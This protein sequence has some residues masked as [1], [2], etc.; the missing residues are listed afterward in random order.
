MTQKHRSMPLSSSMLSLILLLHASSSICAKNEFNKRTTQ[1][2]VEQP[3]SPVETIVI[4]Q[5]SFTV[6]PNS[7]VIG[8]TTIAPTLPAVTVDHAAISVDK[9]NNVYINGS[10]A[11]IGTPISSQTTGSQNSSGL[12]SSYIVTSAFIPSGSTSLLGY[13]IVSPTS[14]GFHWDSNATR[15]LDSGLAGSGT[16]SVLNP[17]ESLYTG[18][19]TASTSS[20]TSH[21]STQSGLLV[22]P[23][24]VSQ[25]VPANS[26][27][28]SSNPYETDISLSST[29]GAASGSQGGS[30]PG[31][32]ITTTSPAQSQLASAI[33]R[34]AT[35][36]ITSRA[37]STLAPGS[38]ATTPGPSATSSS[39]G[40]SA[41]SGSP[42]ETSG[43]SSATSFDVPN[44]TQAGGIP[45]TS[46]P[47]SAPAASSQRSVFGG[48]LLG[49]VSDGRSW[50]TDITLPAIKTRAINEIENLKGNTENAIRNLGGPFPPTSNACSSGASR[51][52]SLNPIGT[53]EGLAGDAL[54]LANCVDNIL[55][56]I[57]SEIG[58]IT[59]PPPPQDVIGPISTLLNALEK[60]GEEEKDDDDHSTT[61]TESSNKGSTST[62]SSSNPSESSAM[63]SLRSSAS[64][65]HSTTSQ[66][67]SQTSSAVS[68][69]PSSI[70]PD[71]NIEEWE[72][73]SLDGNVNKR[74]FGIRG[75]W[76]KKPHQVSDQND[77]TEESLD[78]RH[79][80][81][82]RVQAAAITSINSCNFPN[83]LQGVQPGYSSLGPFKGLNQQRNSQNGRSGQVY[84]AVPKWYVGSHS[85][86][87]PSGFAW[88]KTDDESPT[89]IPSGSKQSVEHVC[90]CLFDSTVQVTR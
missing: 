32:G 34:N 82:K 45:I 23:E 72:G 12:S 4:G 19:G 84:D 31:T 22:R 20:E 47:S 53:V 33:S 29:P 13:P 55:T 51:K 2:N 39:A 1:G 28:A 75:R 54:G 62:G 24:S 3:P 85:C 7:I 79:E 70:Y 67:S 40:V 8:H 27:N 25:S 38:I 66:S 26:P 78:R 73:P 80:L 86:S 48:I 88:Y 16:A 58:P 17:S 15:R 52:R 46:F 6:D 76:Y 43:S 83:G 49:F 61:D 74:T 64:S 50:V 81:M 30:D 10:E 87:L 65:V 68:S 21:L 77:K 42:T 44:T 18:S 57:S 9:S 56:D 71:D 69:C 37:K 35:A 59:G 14:A 5:S 90:Q 89:G 41:P 11:I 60:A 63:T 36:S